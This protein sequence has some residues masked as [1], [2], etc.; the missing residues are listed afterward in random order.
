MVA[1]VGMTPIA[2][3]SSSIQDSRAVVGSGAYSRWT[4]RRT[5]VGQRSRSMIITRLRTVCARGRPFHRQ[6][7][8]ER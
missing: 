3:R 1:Q 6:V 7:V 4:A 8:G 5:L 2:M